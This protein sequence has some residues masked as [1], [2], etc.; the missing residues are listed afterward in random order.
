[1][2]R[3]SIS[4]VSIGINKKQSTLR[5][6]QTIYA[7]QPFPEKGK[8]SLVR[9]RSSHLFNKAK[10]PPKPQFRRPGE[11]YIQIQ[12]ALATPSTKVLN[13]QRAFPSLQRLDCCCPERCRLIDAQSF[14]MFSKFM[15]KEWMTPDSIRTVCLTHG[16]DLENRLKFSLFEDRRLC[17]EIP[18]FRHN[19]RF[20]GNGRVMCYGQDFHRCRSLSMMRCAWLRVSSVLFL[21]QRFCKLISHP[22]ENLLRLNCAPLPILHQR[23]QKYKR[24]HQNVRRFRE[25]KR[26][27]GS[28][29][30]S[31]ASQRCQRLHLIRFKSQV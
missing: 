27:R 24:K 16:C 20:H 1:M 13:S 4:C 26:P 30:A 8:N 22:L 17:D 29:L 28:S 19:W 12:E 10:N 7:S 11:V 21:F 23:A 15:L 31:L 14:P 5:L 3:V 25:S 18:A 2:N 6:R 9:S